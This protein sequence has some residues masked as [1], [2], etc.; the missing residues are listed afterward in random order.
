ML[1]PEEDEDYFSGTTQTPS[2]QEEA[3]AYRKLK[4][5]NELRMAAGLGNFFAVIVGVAALLVLIL[6][7]ISLITW[8]Q[9][10]LY[11]SFSLLLKQF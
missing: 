6:L 3:R 11:H 2:L 7:L 10:D 1:L 8:L 9:S 5:R 4:R